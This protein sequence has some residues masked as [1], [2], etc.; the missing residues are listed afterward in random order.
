MP[1]SEILV[2][3][4]AVSTASPAYVACAARPLGQRNWCVLVVDLDTGLS[5]CAG[6]PVVLAELVATWSI[7]DIPALCAGDLFVSDADGRFH[8]VNSA[9]ALHEEDL[10]AQG[11]VGR[12]GVLAEP[13]VAQVLGA[14]AE[15]NLSGPGIAA[16]R[17]YRRSVRW[18]A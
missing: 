9:G 12:L 11:L 13:L 6:L 16:L 1:E 14:A 3:E 18:P 2:L 5:V 10:D 15:R 7:A 8:S 17:A 4:P